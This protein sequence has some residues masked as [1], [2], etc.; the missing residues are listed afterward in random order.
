MLTKLERV[1]P[2]RGRALPA[3]TAVVVLVALASRQTL[4]AEAGLDGLHAYDDGVYYAGAAALVAGR[5]PYG[6]F[7]FLHP[8]G[9][10]VALSPFAALGALTSDVVGLAAARVAFWILGAVNAALLTRLAARYG[11]VVPA[12][13][14][15]RC[16]RPVIGS[17]PS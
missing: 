2:A 12:G 9:I 10:L 1:R 16:S 11:L 15:R 17:I 13:C 3:L 6:D 7:L 5:V 4:V 14:H 8:P